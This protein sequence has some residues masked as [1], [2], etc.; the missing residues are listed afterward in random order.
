M[1]DFQDEYLPEPENDKPK[2]EDLRKS[3]ERP[4]LYTDTLK[5]I[6]GFSELDLDT[7]RNNMVTRAQRGD[8]G[9]ALQ[10]EADAMWTLMTIM[11]VGAVAAGIA[12]IS[13]GIPTIYLVIGAGI[14]LGSMLAVA[15]R[16][17]SRLRQ[18]SEKMHVRSVQG[19][20]GIRAGRF[21]EGA[22]LLIGDQKLPLSVAQVSA[23]AEYALPSLR[24]YYAE[25][26]KMI[27][28]AEVIHVP[29]KPK[30]EER[31]QLDDIVI[32]DEEAPP[33]VIEGEKTQS[34]K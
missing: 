31:L 19:V 12:A 27:L 23:L 20:P 25:N 15:A 16:R 3:K 22:R 34:M 8:L 2:N 10:E 14:M 11:L 18:D 1:T 32:V 29:D 6:F 4:L 24:V 5:E 21:D 28:S 13:S 9:G 33:L 17:Q 30:N 26:S 7:N